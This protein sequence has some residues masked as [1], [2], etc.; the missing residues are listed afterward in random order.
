M[1]E[2]KQLERDG[3]DMKSSETIIT[4]DMAEDK[5][6]VKSSDKCEIIVNVN[7]KIVSTK[8]IYE[9]LKYE[10]N[11]KY[12]LNC[13]KMEGDVVSNNETKR[14]YNYVYDLFDSIRKAISEIKN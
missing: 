3:R 5:V 2:K 14:L 6:I 12:K 4:I 1:V 8:S 11:K 10:K 7:N 9:F 13:T